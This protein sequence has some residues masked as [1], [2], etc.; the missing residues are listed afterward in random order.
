VKE[1]NVRERSANDGRSDRYDGAVRDTS[2]PLR[3]IP[4]GGGREL[5]A[6][7]VFDTYWRFAIKRQELFLKRVRGEAPP[8]TDDPIIASHRFTN[9]YRASDRVSQYLIRHV[10]YEGDAKP[11]EIFLRTM[12]FKLFNKV[13]TWERLRDRVGAVTCRSFDVARYERALNEIFDG[14]ETLYSAAYIMPS[15]AFGA[16][17]KHANHL[18]LVDH[19]LRDG[20][21]TKIQRAGSLE[22]VFTI[23]RGYPSLGDFLAYQLAIDLNYSEMI[24]FLEKDFVVAGP[25]AKDGIRKCFADTAGLSEAEVI[26]EVC[27]MADDEFRRL[28]LRFQR[29]GDRPLQLIDCQ[30][31]FCEVDKYARVAHPEFVGRTGRTKIKQRYKPN[32]TPLPQKYPPKWNVVLAQAPESVSKRKRRAVQQSLFT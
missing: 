31:L 12:L 2:P 9:V 11:E 3:A 23:L 21:P 19:M 1:V 18:R 24:D 26:G 15:P 28:D 32:A 8:W 10:L 22:E 17:R 29:L 20:A 25:G 27:A 13:G 14:G 30:N 4:I 6:T 5:V 16:V 7:P